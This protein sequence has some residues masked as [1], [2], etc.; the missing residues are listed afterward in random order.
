MAQ[1][2]VRNKY[3]VLDDGEPTAIR[4]DTRTVAHTTLRYYA[5]KWYQYCTLDT[6]EW[7]LPATPAHPHPPGLPNLGQTCYINA[8]V[9]TLL[10]THTAMI[11]TNTQHHGNRPYTTLLRSLTRRTHTPTSPSSIGSNIAS[12]L[13]HCN[14]KLGRSLYTYR[15][16]EVGTMLTD[17]ITLGPEPDKHEG[18]S[19]L[20]LTHITCNN[21]NCAVMHGAANFT[22]AIPLHVPTTDTLAI[23]LQECIARSATI[24]N[25]CAHGVQMHSVWNPKHITHRAIPTHGTV[26]PYPSPSEQTDLRGTPD[27]LLLQRPAATPQL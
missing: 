3:K 21:A 16:A 9:Q 13:H 20:H 10:Q 12:I 1:A 11:N 6:G 23:P 18:N 15:Q 26:L 14:T 24:H 19:V 22:S 2:R 27:P 25:P 8:A 5:A 4:K 7:A 17:L